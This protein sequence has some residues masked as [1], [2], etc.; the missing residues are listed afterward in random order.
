MN[1]EC[2]AIAAREVL[3]IPHKHTSEVVKRQ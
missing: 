1:N 2:R 3:K